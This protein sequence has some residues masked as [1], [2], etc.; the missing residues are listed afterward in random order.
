MGKAKIQMADGML[1]ILEEGTIQKF[2]EKVNQI[3]FSGQCTPDNQEVLYI[4]ER[5]V[6][7]LI[8]HK[9]TLVEIAPGIDLEKDVLGNMGFRPEISPDLK[10]MDPDIFRESWGGLS[11]YL[12]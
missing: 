4:T 5:A 11:K 2:V 10:P 8:D 3:T 9:F 1:T 6:F 7:R 12:K